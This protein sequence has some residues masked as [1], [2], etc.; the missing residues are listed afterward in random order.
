MERLEPLRVYV[1]MIM[2]GFVDLIL[3]G[4]AK[5]GIISWKIDL[6]FNEKI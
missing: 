5:I 2:I 6:F 1:P 4:V 3:V